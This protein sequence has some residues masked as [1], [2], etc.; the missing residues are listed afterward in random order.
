MGDY[1]TYR[2]FLDRRRCW[3]RSCVPT[4]EVQLASGTS[5]TVIPGPTPCRFSSGCLLVQLAVGLIAW[6]TGKRLCVPQTRLRRAPF[7]CRRRHAC[8]RAICGRLFRAE[9]AL[10]ATLFQ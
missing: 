10:L 3:R 8:L 7:V 2:R 4:V 9:L 1:A 5:V 6:A